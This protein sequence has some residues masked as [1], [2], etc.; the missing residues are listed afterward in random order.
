MV[1][2]AKRALEGAVTL[3]AIYAFVTV[4][5]GKRT[6]WQHLKAI[7][8]TDEAQEAGR[9]IKQAGSRILNELLAYDAGEIRGV[10]EVP[11]EL[12]P[13]PSQ[14]LATPRDIGPPDDDEP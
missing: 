11:A 13:A 4:P 2:L 14:S 1:R 12:L 3:F 10:A 8:G 6:G 9:E 7:L 5:L